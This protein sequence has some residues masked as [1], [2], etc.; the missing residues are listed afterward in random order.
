MRTLRGRRDRATWRLGEGLGQVA[1]EHLDVDPGRDIHLMRRTQDA[2]LS[3]G[4][5]YLG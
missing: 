1:V 2:G 5:C 4:L 3:L